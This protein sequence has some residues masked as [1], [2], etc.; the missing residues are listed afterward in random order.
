MGRP[1]DQMHQDDL[2]LLRELFVV[3]ECTDLEGCGREN[4][5]SRA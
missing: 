1:I 4:P 2:Q 3:G 5:R